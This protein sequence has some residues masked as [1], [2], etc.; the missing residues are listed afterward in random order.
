MVVGVAIDDTIPAAQAL[1]ERLHL[2][3]PVLVDTQ[4]MLKKNFS[5]QG[6]PMSIVL[7]AVGSIASFNDPATGAPT[8]K[9]VGPRPWNS[10]AA[11]ASILNLLSSPA[12]PHVALMRLPR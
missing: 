12:S 1:K 10:D 8:R 6:I 9:I 7:N 3:F 5:V 4:Q 2:S 11:R